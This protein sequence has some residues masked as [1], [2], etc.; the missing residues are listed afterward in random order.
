MTDQPNIILIITDQQRIDT[1]GALGA[2]WMHTPNLDRLAREGLSF[3]NCYVTAPLCAPSRASLFTGMYPHAHGVY[4]NFQKWAPSWVQW[5]A[6]AGYHCVNIG[7]MHTNPYDIPGGFHQ[8]IIV[9][10]KDRPLFLDE[11]ERAYYDDWDRALHARGI[12]K[13]T[14]YVRHRHD[15]AAY[16]KAMGAFVW[17]HDD[18]MHSDNFVGDTANWWL[19]ERRSEAPL[20]L[21]IGFPGPHPPFDPTAS[22]L[23]HYQDVDI[24]VPDV[25]AEELAAQPPAHAAYRDAMVKYNQDGVAWK[26]NPD[27][28]ALRR[29]RRHYA[30]NVTMIDA[31]IGTLLDT[32]EQRAGLDNTIVIF[33]SDHGEALG[34]HGHIQKW[35]MYDV[36]VK[37]PLIV[38]SPSRVRQGT[39]DALV[40]LMDVAPTILDQVEISVPQ[41]W[42]ARSFNAL[43]GDPEAPAIRDAVYAELTRGHIQTESEYICMRRDRRYK[44]V[45]YLGEQAG[46]LYDLVKD[47][48]ELVNLWDSADHAAIR[49]ERVALIQEEM[50]RNMVHAQS[51]PMEK[52]QPYMETK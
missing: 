11:H 38:W 12:E 13:P 48:D 15:P 22:A 4:S 1:I 33:T 29:M 24:P 25:S 21:Q 10:N 40:Q 52:P 34:D 50:I 3:S 14:R 6:D 23:A 43:L 35:T 28:E 26:H 30:A 5:L 42:Q 46:E 47:P 36:A 20:F 49:A 27:P 9:E 45:W 18:D 31:K 7:K 8:R 41:G 44:L 39:T 19:Q 16:D 51:R 37:V 17:E 32:L 2:P